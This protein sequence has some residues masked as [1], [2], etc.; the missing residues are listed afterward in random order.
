MKI[1][2]LALCLAASLPLYAGRRRAAAPAPAA[3]SI[4]FVDVP[5]AGATLI[6]AGSEAW[7]DVKTVSQQAGSTGKSVQVRRQFGIRIVRAGGASWGTATVTARLDSQDGRSSLRIDGQRLGSTPI[8]VSSRSAV[9]S[10]T[11]HTL[12]IEVP[13]YVTEGPLAASISWEVT[14][15]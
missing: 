11:V 5:A 15:Q 10:M 1:M 8:V 2:V 13:A 9:G 14:T 6:A 12:E 7:V 3:L 4:E